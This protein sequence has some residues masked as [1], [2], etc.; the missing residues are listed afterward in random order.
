MI[1]ELRRPV[2][3]EEP[4]PGEAPVR[5]LWSGTISFGLVSVPVNMY[6]ANRPTGRALRMLD[7]DGTPLKRRFFCPREE[8]EVH[9]EHIIRG[10]EVEEGKYVVVSDEELE[11]LEPKKSRDID[12]R[13]FVDAQQ[14][15]PIYFER[16]YFLVPGSD[17][18]KAYRLL[19]ATMER[20]G[21]AGVATFVMRDKEYLV[22]IFAENGIMRAETLRFQDE[23]R[24]PEDIGLPDSGQAPPAD[25]TRIEREVRRLEKGR[26]D[27]S[28]LKDEY[29]ERFRKL[30][31]RKRRERR[32]VVEAPEAGEEEPGEPDLI[33]VIRRSMRAAGRGERGNGHGNGHGNGRSARVARSGRA[34]A[35]RPT[36]R[37]QSGRPRRTP[38]QAAPAG[39]S[40]EE[41][42]QRAK[43]LGVEGRSKMG[44]EELLRAIAERGG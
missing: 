37:S 22:A 14:I 28:E 35:K 42:Y 6:P 3:I 31:E 25:V 11:A 4:P 15:D 38:A 34:A 33:E 36:G 13:L 30:V 39:R 21:K 43:K 18:N 44:K 26:F 41:L 24:T 10:Y 5:P 32:D 29:A 23:I 17:S 8:R 7:Q 1:A 2:D 12:L 9:V 20:L 27:P 16:G 19:A 40:R